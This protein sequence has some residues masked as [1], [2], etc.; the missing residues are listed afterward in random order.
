MLELRP[1]ATGRLTLTS[2]KKPILRTVVV[3]LAMTELFACGGTEGSQLDRQAI[4]EAAGTEASRQDDVVRIGWVRDNVAVQ[5]DGAPLPPAAGLGSWAA[6]KP[7]ASGQGAIVMGDTVVFQDEVDAA[8]DAAFANGLKVTALHNHFFYDRPK[9]YF[10]HIG[11]RGPA[12]EL[13]AGVK[14]V[15]DAIRRVRAETPEPARS[16]RGAPPE[17]GGE[18]D[19]GRIAEITGLE[20]SEKPGGVVK[21]SVGRE[22]LMDGTGIGGAMG[23]GT[24]AAFAGSMESASVDG[25]FIMTGS[26]VRPVL[27][28]LRKADF[29]VV[30]LHNHMIGEEPTF[31]FTHYWAKGP[32]AELA[33]GFKAALDAQAG[34]R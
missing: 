29:H 11:G 34:V 17:R 8:M 19:A 21:V 12:S 10:M 9:A 3:S 2:M 28:A 13:A 26:E 33:A 23:L 31:Y 15:W 25:D 22:G 16:F 32:A 27:K 24:W 6:F 14:A 20:A 30:A 7:A 1:D 5:V 18:L 4:A